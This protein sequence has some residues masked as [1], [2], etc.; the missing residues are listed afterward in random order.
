M[1]IHL[2]LRKEELELEGTITVKEALKKFGL[3][4]ESFFM[5]RD[6]ILLNEND[7]LRNG[8]HVKIIAVISGG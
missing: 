4:S 6:G 5:L 7:V 2:S 8:E 1:P 3:S